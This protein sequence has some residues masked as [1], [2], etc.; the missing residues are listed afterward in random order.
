MFKIAVKINGLVALLTS[1]S[2]LKTLAVTLG[3]KNAILSRN[4][5][6]P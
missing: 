5:I 2:A 1:P 4:I 6:C 3:S